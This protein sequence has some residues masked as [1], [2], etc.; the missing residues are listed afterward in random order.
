MTENEI[1]NVKNSLSNN[2]QLYIQK[3]IEKYGNY[4]PEERLKFL[5]SITNF[6][7]F[8]KIE[9]YGSV[10][11]YA[12]NDGVYMPLCAD[13]I[14]SL[15]GKFP[16]YG[17][18]K[19]HKGY[20]N[21]NLVINNNTFINYIYHVFVSGTD[22]QGYYEDMLLHET[23]HFCGSGGSTALK[24]GINEF[25]TRKVALENNFRT[26]ASGYPKEVKVAYELQELLGEE[27][28]NQIAF[29]NDEREIFIFLA[30]NVSLNAAA[31]YRNVSEEM[32]KE[33]YE[34]YYKEID[35]YDGITGIIKKTINYKKIDYSKVYDLLNKYKLDLENSEQLSQN[36]NI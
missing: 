6:N 3:I 23:M 36:Y 27:I 21:D 33:F 24:E 1:N 32:E 34:K 29:I 12:S 26:N 14:L 31:L 2:L 35:T 22:A 20:N 19:S 25:L 5:S 4:I 28:I 8:I 10:N 15:A 9:D 16:L 7:N 13:R 17:V 30:N 18:N 11:A